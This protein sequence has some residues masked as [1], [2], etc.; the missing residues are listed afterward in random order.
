MISRPESK[1]QITQMNADKAMFERAMKFFP[2]CV[3]L[4]HL[5]LKL[6]G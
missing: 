1:P 5:R 6:Y 2:I 4:R 3:H